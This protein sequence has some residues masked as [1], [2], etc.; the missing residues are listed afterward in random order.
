VSQVSHLLR[1]D[2]YNVLPIRSPTVP[3]GMERL[4]ICLHSHNKFE[5]VKGFIDSL[6]RILGWEKKKK[7]VNDNNSN[8]NDYPHNNIIRSNL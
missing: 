5:D 8:H 1:D 3:I 2:G 4:R 6:S 7:N